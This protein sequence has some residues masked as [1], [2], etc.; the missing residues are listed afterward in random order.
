MPVNSSQAIP[1]VLKESAKQIPFVCFQLINAD[2]AKLPLLPC[3]LRGVESS[4]ADYAN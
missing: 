1:P 3:T 4:V 2:Y